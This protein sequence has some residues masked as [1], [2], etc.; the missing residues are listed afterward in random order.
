[1]DQDCVDG[2]ACSVAYVSQHRTRKSQHSHKRHDQR[3]KNPFTEKPAL[4]S[5]VRAE[6]TQGKS[7]RSLRT[8]QTLI[9]PLRS[10]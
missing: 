9:G 3:R 5:I 4:S 6:M 1:M 7:Q 8:Q 10:V 2:K